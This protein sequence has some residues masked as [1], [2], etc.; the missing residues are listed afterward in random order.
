MIITLTSSLII[1]IYDNDST[2]DSTL[3]LSE[4]IVNHMNE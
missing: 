3:A 2:G 4:M 1:M